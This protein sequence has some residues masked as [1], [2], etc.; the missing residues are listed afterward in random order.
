MNMNAKTSFSSYHSDGSILQL[1]PSLLRL[2]IYFSFK[3]F[4][5]HESQYYALSNGAQESRKT[6]RSGWVRTTFERTPEMST[7][8]TAMVITNYR[9]VFSISPTTIHNEM[10]ISTLQEN[11]WHHLV[12]VVIF[13]IFL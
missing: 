9:W 7:Y 1:V 5:D 10:E 11:R 13:V 3:F 2:L 12:F 8:I 4:V 6:I